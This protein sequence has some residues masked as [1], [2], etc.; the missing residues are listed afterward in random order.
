MANNSGGSIV[1]IG[2]IYGMV[3]PKHFIYEYR[4]QRGEK[5]YKP[6]AY[7][8]SKGSLYNLTK[9]LATYWG[10]R[11]VRVNCLTLAG[12]FN[13][14]DA[15]FMEAYL[16]NVPMGRMADPNDYI[17]PLIFLSTSASKYVTGSNLVV[18]GGWTAW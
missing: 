7:S 16:K 10:S 5:F 1:N 12:V 17:G 6:I 11:N 4:H 8:V 13:H 15:Q 9:Y 18:D 2:S 14:Q 3:S